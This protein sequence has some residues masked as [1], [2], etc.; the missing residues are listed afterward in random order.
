MPNLQYRNLRWLLISVLVIIVD[1]VTKYFAQQ[2]LTFAEPK[3]IF[4]GFA[5]TL[6]HNTG[7]AFGFL[8]EAA[9]WQRWFFIGLAVVIGLILI[10]CLLRA[11]NTAYGYLTAWSLVIGGAIGNVIDRFHS[12]YVT[13]FLDFYVGSYHWPAFNIA[14]SAIVVG[15]IL[16]IF[17]SYK[18]S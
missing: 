11:K 5:L 6:L 13:D 18:S 2:Y 3:I 12:T 16:L 10:S 7:A 4:P 17:K 9:G 8:A 1:Q 14:D 15:V